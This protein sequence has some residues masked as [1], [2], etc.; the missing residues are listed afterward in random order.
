MKCFYISI[1]KNLEGFEFYKNLWEKHGVEGIRIDSMT[2]GIK[3]AIEIE[4]STT[5]ELCFI[6][7]VSG[8]VDYLPQLKILSEE[9]NAPILVAAFN[10]S[11]EEHCDALNNGADYYGQYCDEPDS[12]IKFVL[13][14][15]N[16]IEKRNKKRKIPNKI[17]LHND[18]LIVDGYNRVFVND[19]EI[20]LT[21][22]EMKVFRYLAIN[23]GNIVSH[24]Q[25][26]THIKSYSPDEPS[27]NSVYSTIKRLRKKLQSAT[28][29]DYIETVR[30]F[31]Y[32]LKQVLI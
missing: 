12:N 9:T 25:I 18:I 28:Q 20:H 10:Y 1:E 24:K 5:G 19:K 26:Y 4:K 27:S 22:A 8:S 17:L 32:R 7:I 11:E 16:S 21:G 31:G 15:V 13:S 6:A 14:V 29:L 30:N 23:R 2:E 3:K